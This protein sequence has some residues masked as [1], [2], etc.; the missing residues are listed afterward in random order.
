MTVV[1]ASA[2]AELLLKLPLGSAAERHVF[3][4]AGAAAPDLLNA[5]ILHVLRRYELRGIIDAGRSREALADLLDLPITRYPTA[6][7]LERAWAL[8][9]NLTAYDAIYAALAEA[10]GAPLITTDAK[11]A[12]AARTHAR[13]AVVVL[14]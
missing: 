13:I 11:L 8:R 10:L 6:A 9:W 3:D 4:G 7:L 14:A 5:E 1:D 2:V 12:S